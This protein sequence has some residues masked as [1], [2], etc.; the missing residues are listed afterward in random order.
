MNWKPINKVIV[1]ALVGLVVAAA[2]RYI[3]AWH[4]GVPASVQTLIPYAAAMLSAYLV[5]LEENL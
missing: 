3:P 1:G 4:N 5:K 2:Q